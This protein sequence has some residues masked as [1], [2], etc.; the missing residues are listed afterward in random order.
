MISAHLSFD[1]WIHVPTCPFNHCNLDISQS[2]C[3]SESLMCPTLMPPAPL[4]CHHHR[5]PA[6]PFHPSSPCIQSAFSNHNVDVYRGLKAPRHPPSLSLQPSLAPSTPWS[7][8]W[9]HMPFRSRKDPLVHWPAAGCASA[10]HFG[11]WV[12]PSH[13]QRC[14]PLSPV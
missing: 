13:P 9:S 11:S 14:L 1:L 3:S 2:S 7:V 4:H 6:H 10:E 5:P 12:Y 8:L